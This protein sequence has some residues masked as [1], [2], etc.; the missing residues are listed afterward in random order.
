VR[1]HRG[2]RFGID[3]QEIHRESEGSLMRK[4]FEYRLYP[5]AAQQELLRVQLSEACRRYNAALQERRDAYKSHGKSL[6]YCDQANQLKE[7]RASGTAVRVVE[8][9]WPAP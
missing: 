2:A 3:R 1:W 4:T 5:N 9:V 6:N 8:K 7:I